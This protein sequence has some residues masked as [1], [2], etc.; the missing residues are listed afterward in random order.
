[1]LIGASALFFFLPGS[2]ERTMSDRAIIAVF[3]SSSSAYDAATAIRS[4]ADDK[5]IDF[6]VSSGAMFKKDEKGNVVPLEEKDRH[7]WGTMGGAVAG[8]LIGALAGPAG[9]AAGAAI[10]ATAG[11]TGDAVVASLD[12]GFVDQVS[13]EL[14]PGDTAVV[15][16]AN[17]GSTAAV[18]NIVRLNGGRVYRSELH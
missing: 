11:L 15:V 7:L 6:K 16:E 18:D 5:L 14:N 1:L 13:Q 3:N 9:A 8:G 12:T 4:L 10:G 17:E 2:W